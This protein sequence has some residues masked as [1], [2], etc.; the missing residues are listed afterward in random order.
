M[1]AFILVFLGMFILGG[2]IGYFV[3]RFGSKLEDKIRAFEAKNKPAPTKPSVT[4]GAYQPPKSISTAVESKQG[5]GLVE[6]KTP[7]RLDW[8]SQEELRKLEHSS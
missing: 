5:A 4:G 1:Y 8:E 2:V 6:S 7:E 3:G